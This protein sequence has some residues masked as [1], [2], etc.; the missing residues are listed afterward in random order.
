MATKTKKAKKK[1]LKKTQKTTT[2]KRTKTKVRSFNKVKKTAKKSQKTKPKKKTVKPVKK[3]IKREKPKKRKK[4]APKSKAKTRI[5][6]RKTNKPIKK[7]SVIQISTTVQ[8]SQVDV[9]KEKKKFFD[10]PIKTGA[11]KSPYVVDIYFENDAQPRLENLEKQTPGQELGIEQ[12][13]T[14]MNQPTAVD[15]CVAD[16][17]INLHELAQDFNK[18]DLPHPFYELYLVGVLEALGIGLC[19]FQQGLIWPFSKFKGL[20]P[21]FKNR[22]I[23]TPVE[24]ITTPVKI[25]PPKGWIRG[26]VSIAGLA[27]VLILPFQGYTYYQEIKTSQAEIQGY[28]E[29]AKNLLASL[30][31]V[32]NLDDALS[33]LSEAQ[34]TINLAQQE[35]NQINNLVVEIA[36]L[37]PHAGKKVKSGEAL[38]AMGD[39]LVQAATI[40]AKGVQT[41]LSGEGNMITK[42]DALLSY[43]EQAKPAIITAR[44]QAELVDPG[45]L[46]Q[47]YEKTFNLIFENLNYLEQNLDD[48]IALG[49]TLEIMLGK[50]QEQRYLFIF[51]NNNELRP[52]GGFMGSFALIDIDRGEIQNIEVPGGGTYDMQGSLDTNVL[53][54]EP[55]RLIADRWELQDANWFPDFPTSA[56]KIIWFYEHSGG[57][58][59]DGV[60]VVTATFMEQLLEVYGP[61]AMPEYGRTFTAENFIDEVQVIVEVEYDKEENKP[62]KVIGDLAPIMLEK[63]LHANKEQMLATL[64][65]IKRAL[66]EKHVLI[67]SKNQTVS[68]DLETRGWNGSVKQTDGDFLMVINSN[69]AGGKTDG[70]I[71]QEYDLNTEI[72]EQG[73]IINTLKITRTHTGIKNQGFSGVN[74]VNYLR[75]YVP[76]GAE[77]ISASGFMPPDEELFDEPLEDCRVDKDL[78][79]LEGSWGYH[80]SGVKINN[81]FGKTVF[82]SWTQTMPGT[83][84]VAEFKYRLPFRLETPKQSFI[85]TIKEKLGFPTTLAY[86]LFWQKQPG[87]KEIKYNQRLILPA[88]MKKLWS[89]IPELYQGN[90]STTLVRDT[91]FALLLEKELNF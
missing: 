86:T 32:E 19:K 45:S 5:S 1:P 75:V 77:L 87:S 89:N 69:I 22:F 65:V 88:G 17:E 40:I 26:L 50:D 8:A 74:N 21:D 20:V 58:T 9:P 57:A 79:E 13:L 28:S 70:V 73:E 31:Q 85:S 54:P 7:T 72:S 48:L 43:V 29:Q 84:T 81:E 38:L 47:E 14:A 23:D 59:P 52:T 55:L 36:G 83:E 51:E 78:A 82:A 15:L 12:T 2:K 67:Y 66:A 49:H 24:K 42:V 18:P 37:I 25:S 4:A 64:E 62:K 56:E 63:I 46:P 3:T 41:L 60:I 71:E 80:H 61:I 39:N 6:R 35:L 90:I 91:F 33:G 34:Q 44:E 10:I 16:H 30:G 76:K 53:A 11:I 27:L 68:Q